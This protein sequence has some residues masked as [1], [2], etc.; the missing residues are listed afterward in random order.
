MRS[1]PISSGAG[2]T[3]QGWSSRP[4]LAVTTSD[5]RTWPG[6]FSDRNGYRSPLR[7]GWVLCEGI[8]TLGRFAVSAILGWED[9]LDPAG[10]AMVASWPAGADRFQ[11]IWA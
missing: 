5:W 4:R 1:W 3:T 6:A 2:N 9:I 10:R 7:C 11:V 8:Q